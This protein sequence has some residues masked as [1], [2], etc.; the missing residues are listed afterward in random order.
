MLVQIDD[1]ALMK[2]MKQD[3]KMKDITFLRIHFDALCKKYRGQSNFSHIYIKFVFSNLLKD[4]YDNIPVLM[5]R[6]LAGR[7]TDCI[8]QRI[9]HALWIS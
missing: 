7:L 1:D 6:N 2:Q 3:I 4:F 9:S 5:R 8:S